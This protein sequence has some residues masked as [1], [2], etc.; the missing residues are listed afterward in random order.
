MTELY[1]LIENLAKR[2]SGMPIHFGYNKD[3]DSY[4]MMLPKDVVNNVNERF[5]NFNNDCLGIVKS[6]VGGKSFNIVPDN[7]NI[8]MDDLFKSFN[9]NKGWVVIFTR[10]V[11]LF[12]GVDNYVMASTVVDTVTDG[13]VKTNVE[14]IESFDKTLRENYLSKGYN[15]VMDNTINTE[16]TINW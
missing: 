11:V 7:S 14:A 5:T 4:I 9:K 15:I 1:G 16:M 6:Y 12:N 3:M 8:Y 10:V 2:Y 13:S